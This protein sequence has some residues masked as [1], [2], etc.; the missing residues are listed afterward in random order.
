MV[1]RPADAEHAKS[2]PWSHAVITTPADDSKAESV[3]RGGISGESGMKINQI[4]KRPRGSS[5]RRRISGCCGVDDV[6]VGVVL[7]GRLRED[8]RWFGQARASRVRSSAWPILSD[9]I[10][11]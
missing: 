4:D 6:R 3:I 2:D 10:L 8:G 1:K 9:V 5:Y 11:S 7:Q